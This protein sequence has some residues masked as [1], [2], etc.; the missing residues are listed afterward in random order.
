M[1][2][3]HLIPLLLLL[4][5]TGPQKDSMQKNLFSTQEIKLANT[6][7]HA[8]WMSDEEKRVILYMNL[9]RMDGKRFYRSFIPDYVKRHNQIFRPVIH[10]NNPYLKS[11]KTDLWKIKNLSLLQPDSLLHLAAAFHAKDMGDNGMTGHDSSD[12]TDFSDR[13]ERFKPDCFSAAENCAY[14]LFDALD[15]VCGLLIDDEVPCLGHR[16]NILNHDFNTAGVSIWFHQVYRYNCVIDF[17][18]L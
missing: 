14:G 3:L 11:L 4:I 5:G 18:G 9:A 12:G 16:I 6:A 7:A 1:Q 10:R 17:C 8:S 13:L 15:I 2:N